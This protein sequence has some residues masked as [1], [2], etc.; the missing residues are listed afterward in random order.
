MTTTGL[1]YSYNLS[2]DT[3]LNDGDLL[4]AQFPQGGA[5]GWAYS[6]FTYLGGETLRQVA[7]RSLQTT[8]PVYSYALTW[9]DANNSVSLHTGVAL[10][11]GTS[12]T[13]KYWYFQLKRRRLSRPGIRTAIP[14]RARRH[15]AAAARRSVHLGDRRQ[16]QLLCRHA[17][18][19]PQ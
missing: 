6:N 17:A 10:D 15:L 5:L 14:L 11:D 12:G 2:Y 4:K 3:T 9:P 8:T 19:H 18:D 13:E 7:G 1:G 16:R